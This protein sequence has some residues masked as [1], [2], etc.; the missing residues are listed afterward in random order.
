MRC[1]L[2]FLFQSSS[3]LFCLSLSS[4]SLIEVKIDHSLNF[5]TVGFISVQNYRFSCFR[6]SS[7]EISFFKYVRFM[8][9]M[10]QFVGEALGYSLF[11]LFFA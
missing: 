6:L 1:A 2:L 7:A 10:D 8:L 3:L 5:E 9:K 4:S 11:S